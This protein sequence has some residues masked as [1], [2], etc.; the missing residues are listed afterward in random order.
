MEAKLKKKSEYLGKR[1]QSQKGE[2]C[3]VVEY[4]NCRR[5]GVIFDGYSDIYWT[6][7]ENLK[8][9]DLYNKGSHNPD[10]KRKYFLGQRFYSKTWGVSY[11]SKWV[12][13]GKAEVTFAGNYPCK[14]FTEPS[15][16]SKGLVKN[17]MQPNV[18]GKGF[19]GIGKYDSSS[20]AY[21][22]WIGIMERCYGNREKLTSYKGSQVCDKWLNFQNFAVDYYKMLSEVGFEDVQVDKDLMVRGSRGKMYSPETC[23][24]LPHSINTALQL[25]ETEGRDLPL[26]V[27]L[28]KSSGKYRVQISKY[29]KNRYMGLFNSTES[30]VKYYNRLKSEYILELS[31]VYKNKLPTRTYTALLNKAKEVLN[32]EYK[33]TNTL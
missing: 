29:G 15:N 3:T 10:E 20:A 4:V 12:E 17:P 7:T 23:C 11:I 2:W 30:A 19:F 31:E 22:A 16:L 28:H 27:S 24:I 26:G 32:D 14:V 1:Y 18:Y 9:G 5:V 13:Y 6:R 21:Q 33:T 8:T 25:G